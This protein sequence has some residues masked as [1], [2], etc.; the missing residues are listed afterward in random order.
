MAIAVSQ[1][2]VALETWAG[3]LLTDL[4]P[5]GRRALLR[6]VA[7]DLRRAN[8]GRI[9]DQRNPDGTAYEPRKRRD[10]PLRAK[11]GRIKRRNEA[12]KD[13]MFR[14][15]RLARHMTADWSENAA[16]V[17]FNGP[18]ARIARVHQLGLLD[19]VERRQDAPIVRYPQRVLLGFTDDD[20]Q[21]LLD[22]VMGRLQA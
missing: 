13:P 14:K 8:Y 11:A 12:R 19:R 16:S 10:P 3:A 1:D 20:R 15:L 7:V 4:S 21:R 6:S 5:A 22:L 18:A 9:V 17:G 2:L